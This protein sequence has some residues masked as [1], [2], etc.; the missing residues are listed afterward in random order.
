MISTFFVLAA[1]SVFAS[2]SARPLTRDDGCT[3]SF[4]GYPIVVT[5][6]DADAFLTIDNV[7]TFYFQ[8]D[9]Q[10]PASFVVKYVSSVILKFMD[11]HLSPTDRNPTNTNQVATTVGTDFQWKPANNA[12][13]DWSQLFNV[14]CNTCGNKNGVLGDRCAIQS[15]S[16]GLC[17]DAVSGQL[18]ACDEFNPAQ[19]FDLVKAPEYKLK[20]RH[21]G[22]PTQTDD[23]E[24]EICA[25]A[26]NG[27]KISVLT[28]NEEYQM[29]I[30][31]AKSFVL[32]QASKQDPRFMIRDA[33]N[34][35]KAVTLVHN[36]VVLKPVSGNAVDQLWNVVC[37]ACA[38]VDYTRKVVADLC[39]IATADGSKCWDTGAE[40][41]Q[42]CDA[43]E[44]QLFTLTNGTS[45]II[46]KSKADLGK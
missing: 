21:G 35:N 4:D 9:G 12:G 20:K 19:S 36:D 42:I 17:L 31:G 22:H 24:V 8:Q 6:S 43:K 16:S 40:K 29:I 37:L 11:S 18:K 7:S 28:V 39:F 15:V 14:V 25:P 41:L 27:E 46:G 32:Q 30:D 13:N 1:T 5:S 10:Q 2:V 34:A 38:P 33:Q 26:T 3:P 23:S 44:S 45:S